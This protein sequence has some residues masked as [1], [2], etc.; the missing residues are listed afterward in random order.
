MDQPHKPRYSDS[1]LYDEVCENCGATDDRP[2]GLRGACPMTAPGAWASPPAL[3]ERSE[4]PGYADA[5]NEALERVR[6]EDDFA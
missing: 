3:L 4:A 5:L 2:G 1:S 6:A